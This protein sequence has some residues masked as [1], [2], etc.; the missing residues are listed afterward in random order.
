MAS[1]RWMML[2]VVL[3]AVLLAGAV[4][5]Q[6]PSPYNVSVYGTGGDP[7]SAPL[8]EWVDAGVPGDQADDNANI[9]FY[10]DWMPEHPMTVWV[11]NTG[12]TT[13]W[14]GWQPLN[15][16]PRGYLSEPDPDGG[17]GDY[18]M[19]GNSL[20]FGDEFGW[21]VLDMADVDVS[22]GFWFSYYD[23]NGTPDLPWDDPNYV[24]PEYYM[25]LA[26]GSNYIFNM[27]V[28]DTDINPD[29]PAYPSWAFG[30]PV[31]EPA[32]VLLL[33]SG[34]LGLGFLRKKKEV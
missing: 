19:L 5:A 21:P 22:R 2:S 20:G 10:T 13:G 3:A 24:N 28:D 29:N 11:Y 32:S 6:T 34:L 27:W 17:P 7:A 33:G 1:K 31:P 30:S 14:S 4:R 26:D 15:D 18:R 25:I 16:S 23:G 9:Y 8:G 12:A